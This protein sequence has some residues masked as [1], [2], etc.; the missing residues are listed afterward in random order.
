MQ[1]RN[2]Q[3]SNVPMSSQSSHSL[4]TLLCKKRATNRWELRLYAHK[5]KQTHTHAH[6]I[7]CICYCFGAVAEQTTLFLPLSFALSLSLTA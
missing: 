1:Q 4:R 7:I 5:G 2:L 3:L 6:I